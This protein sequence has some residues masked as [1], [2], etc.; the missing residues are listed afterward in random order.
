MIGLIGG[1]S[2]ASSAEYYRR[3]NNKI[4]LQSTS[5]LS[6]CELLMYSFNFEEILQIQIID[7]SKK[8]LEILQNIIERLVK[9]GVTKIGICSNT[10]SKTIVNLR[11]QNPTNL[12]CVI[13]ATRDFVVKKGYHRVGLLG[14]MRTM[15]QSYYSSK[16]ESSGVQ[17]C[18]PKKE[19]WQSVHDVIYDRLCKGIVRD[20]DRIKIESIISSNWGDGK[21]D[22]VILGCTELPLLRI[23]S[24]LPLIDCIDCHIDQLL[25]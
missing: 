5:N 13:E 18:T 3:L 20:A 11:E 10:T 19:D 23:E 6:S 2:W 8:E 12:V 17:V 21:V 14:T 7:D 25:S 4:A 22:A 16:F 9:F 1:V 15:S 24:S